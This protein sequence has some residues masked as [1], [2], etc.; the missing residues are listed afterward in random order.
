MLGSSRHSLKVM[1]LTGFIILMCGAVQ[2][3]NAE[4]PESGSA[5]DSTA[6]EAAAGESES[7]YE[8]A[9]QKYREQISV[10][11]RRAQQIVEDAIRE[12]RQRA[13]ELRKQ[14]SAAVRAEFVTNLNV[15]ITRAIE[16]GNLDRAAH[17]TK[18]RDAFDGQSIPASGTDPSQ[19]V[20]NEIYEC[21]LGMY[22]QFTTGKNHPVV[23]LAVPNRNLWSEEIQGKLRGRI[24]FMEINYEATAKLI[25]PSDGAYRVELPE[26][27]TEFLINGN[28]LS[29]GDVLL[30]QGVY[31]ICIKTGTHGQPFLPESFVRIVAQQND[32]EIALVNTGKDIRRFLNSHVDNQAVTEVSG[33]QPVKAER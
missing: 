10:I 11:E 25:I 4:L 29:A 14:E 31:D 32:Q 1:F 24:D 15:A 9:R 8:R 18:E 13:S 17:L 30:K 12:A 19:F 33:Y 2:Q 20:D 6:V 23:N 5:E 7:S 16:N 21:V 22:G 28:Q 3:I 27:G 26:R